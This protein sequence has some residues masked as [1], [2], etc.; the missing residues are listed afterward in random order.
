MNFHGMPA[1]GLAESPD[2][3]HEPARVR[4]AGRRFPNGMFGRTAAGSGKGAAKITTTECAQPPEKLGDAAGPGTGWQRERGPGDAEVKL[5]FH[6]LAGLMV[7][8]DFFFHPLLGEK[9]LKVVKN[10]ELI[11]AFRRLKTKG[12]GRGPGLYI[13]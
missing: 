9:W 1:V 3:D 12:P 4:V 8:I 5:F 10:L 7:A 6:S 11:P 2:G 13:N